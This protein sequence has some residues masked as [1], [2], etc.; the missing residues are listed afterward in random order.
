MRNMRLFMG[1][2]GLPGRATKQ[3]CYTV[4]RMHSAITSYH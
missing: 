4:V 2:Y 1:E 3:M